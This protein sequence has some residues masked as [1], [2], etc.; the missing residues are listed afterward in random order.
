MLAGIAFS[1]LTISLLLPVAGVWYM[2][3]VVM[4]SFLAVAYLLLRPRG[5]RVA[6]AGVFCL[7]GMTTPVLVLSALGLYRPVVPWI[8]DRLRG[9]GGP[10]HEI[11]QAPDG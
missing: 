1:L 7:G 3:A 9:A 5:V 4:V 6:W 10:A 8:V 11:R 2:C